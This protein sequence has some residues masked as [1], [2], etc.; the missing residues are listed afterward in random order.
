LHDFD[1]VGVEVMQLSEESRV[2]IASGTLRLNLPKRD[3]WPQHGGNEKNAAFL[4]TF[5]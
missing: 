4:E 5:A 3:V 1:A 2:F